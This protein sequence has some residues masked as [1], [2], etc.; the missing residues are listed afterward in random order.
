MN[1]AIWSLNKLFIMAEYV[2]RNFILLPHI[3]SQ[4]VQNNRSIDQGVVAD[5]PS[6]LERSQHRVKH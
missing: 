5:S 4:P 1:I 3:P 6:H 2:I